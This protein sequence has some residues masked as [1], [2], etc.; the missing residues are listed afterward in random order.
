M[1]LSGTLKTL[2]NFIFGHDT[3][4]YRSCAVLLNNQMMV[5][6]GENESQAW[7]EIL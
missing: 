6:G 7:T 4:V 5:F 2:D 3:Q 1:Q